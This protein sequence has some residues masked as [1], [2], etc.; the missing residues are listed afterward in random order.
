VLY[1]NGGIEE[2]IRKLHPK[3]LE[4]S[5]LSLKELDTEILFQKLLTF[6]KNSAKNTKFEFHGFEHF[7]DP[8]SE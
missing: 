1:S 7:H 8:E 6:W 2:Q 3:T 5:I 4:L